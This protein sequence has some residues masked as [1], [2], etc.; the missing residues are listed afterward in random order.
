[1]DHWVFLSLISEYGDERLMEPLI[2]NMQARESVDEKNVRAC[3]PN[4][5]G[6]TP[7]DLGALNRLP[8]PT[9]P[10]NNEVSSCRPDIPRTRERRGG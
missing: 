7:A 3:Q 2:L 9:V 4:R 6:N 5:I 10:P 1:M 8:E